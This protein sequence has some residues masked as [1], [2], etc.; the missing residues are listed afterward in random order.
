VEHAPQQRQ[1]VDRN[2]QAFRPQ[3]QKGVGRV[4]Q[5]EQGQGRQKPAEARVEG[6][7]DF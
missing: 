4:G 2:T 1:I 6:I 3:Q 5:H 7:V